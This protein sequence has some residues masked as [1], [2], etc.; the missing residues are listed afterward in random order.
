MTDI[1]TLN[2]LFFLG[3]VI[4]C[5]ITVTLFIVFILCWNKYR[6]RKEIMTK[7]FD[8]HKKLRS[9]KEAYKVPRPPLPPK[10]IHRTSKSQDVQ[11]ILPH[12]NKA[13]DVSPDT[14]G[15]DTRHMYNTFHDS[16]MSELSEIQYRF[17]RQ[18]PHSQAST[19]SE[20]SGF[21]SSRS[22]Q[23][24]HSAQNSNAQEL[25]LFKPLDN[26]SQPQTVNIPPNCDN[27]RISSRRSRR[28]SR[29]PANQRTRQ[30]CPANQRT[31]Q[32]CVDVNEI[33]KDIKSQPLS[34][35]S[36]QMGQ[37]T[38]TM[39]TVHHPNIEDR[40]AAMAYSVV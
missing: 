23:Y 20:D 18:R 26:I 4:P 12:H 19:D 29:S 31:K 25:P 15:D 5:I 9:G 22:G 10:W 3:I 38:V 8:P 39:A 30:E 21:R 6:L 1:M 33:L 35:I 17:E 14:P 24:L 34:V 27:V 40:G 28:K 7:K 13:F 11:S 2:Y 37:L 16:G 36:P 32:K